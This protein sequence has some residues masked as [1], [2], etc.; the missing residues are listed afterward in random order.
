VVRGLAYLSASW[1][2][3]GDTSMV[4]ENL[5]KP[6]SEA[7]GLT[8]AGLRDFFVSTNVADANISAALLGCIAERRFC[9]GSRGPREKQIVKAGKI[10]RGADWIV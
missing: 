9:I 2:T 10:W 4:E 3:E 6:M 7:R 8:F 1:D 5:L